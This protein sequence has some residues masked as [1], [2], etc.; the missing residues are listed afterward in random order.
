MC[1]TFRLTQL[2]PLLSI[3]PGCNRRATWAVFSSG[4]STG[5]N[6]LSSLSRLMAPFISWQLSCKGT[7][8][9]AGCQM[10]ATFRS[11]ELPA[12]PATCSSPQAV[13]KVLACFFKTSWR[14]SQSTGRESYIKKSHVSLHNGFSN[15]FSISMFLKPSHSPA[16]TQAEGAVQEHE[17]LAVTQD[18]FP[19]T[20]H[21]E[22]VLSQFIPRYNFQYLRARVNHLWT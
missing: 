16:H 21:V 4:V 2:G 14:L 7:S 9:L 10:K 19:H 3:L 8:P 12:V 20:I 1:Q 15:P 18:V 5:K 17:W 22:N 6:Q 11:L 13:H